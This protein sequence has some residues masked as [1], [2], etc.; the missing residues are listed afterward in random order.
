MTKKDVTP[1]M[2]ELV[3]NLNKRM[4]K[5]HGNTVLEKLSER[6]KSDP[7]AAQFSVGDVLYIDD[8]VNNLFAQPLGNYILTGVTCVCKNGDHVCAKALY[9]SC[10]DRAI[11]EY[12]GNLQPTGNVVY[13]KTDKVHDVYDAFAACTDEK[14]VYNLLKGKTLEVT[15]INEVTAARYNAAGQITGTRLRKVAVFTFVK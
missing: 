9:F 3:S 13:A 7:Q 14:E 8:D 11:A 15:D 12:G 1:E 5:N 4:G 10:L 6:I 2:K